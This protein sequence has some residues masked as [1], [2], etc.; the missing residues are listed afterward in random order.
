MESLPVLLGWP[1]I[2]LAL[3]LSAI[4]IIR[5]QYALLFV[6]AGL[7]LPASLYLTGSPRIGWLGL[8]VVFLVAGAGIA[9]KRRRA[10]TARV[11]YLPVVAALSHLAALVVTQ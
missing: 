1:A 4:G 3:V 7:L 5:S 8:A 2:A 9:V 6:G 10:K 11:L